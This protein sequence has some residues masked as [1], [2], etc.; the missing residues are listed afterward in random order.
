[1]RTEAGKREEENIDNCSGAKKIGKQRNQ[2]KLQCRPNSSHNRAQCRDRTQG[3][4]SPM[5]CHGRV[6][7]SDST[8]RRP[9]V[10]SSVWSWTAVESTVQTRWGH[11][12]NSLE[13]MLETS[14]EL[15]HVLPLTRL[16]SSFEEVCGHVHRESKYD[17]AVHKRKQL[18]A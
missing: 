14:G 4:G 18:R 13:L 16:L 1:M 15:I 9:C 10:K 7:A 12:D 6:T 8:R 2:R 11:E 5:R 3:T 17:G